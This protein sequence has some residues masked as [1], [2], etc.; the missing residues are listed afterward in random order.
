MKMNKFAYALVLLVAASLLIAACG[1]TNSTNNANTNTNQPDVNAPVNN[2]VQPNEPAQPSTPNTNVPAETPDAVTTDTTASDTVYDPDVAVAEIPA[3]QKVCAA[4]ADCVPL[5]AC[6]PMEC[7]N[8]E[9]A[10]KYTKPA[11]CTPGLVG[12]AAESQLDCSCINKA[13]KNENAII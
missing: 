13:C 11:T 10:S 4:N 2:N 9:F 3:E 8:K 7:I 5:P 1:K 6:H 12:R